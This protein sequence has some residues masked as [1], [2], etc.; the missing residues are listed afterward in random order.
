MRRLLPFIAVLWSLACGSDST[1]PKA[2]LT[3]TW[4]GSLEAATVQLSLTQSGT[5]VTGSGTITAGTTSLPVTV[6][7]TANR[8]SFSL[9]ISASG[10]SP[11]NFAGTSGTTT[12][13]GTVNGS[14]YTNAA[15][16]L[17]KQ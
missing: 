3:G 8:P 13:T 7:G 17:T 10:F 15:V 1:E 16:T 9:T 14:G 5:D 2:T 12:L 11:I 4:R 6:A